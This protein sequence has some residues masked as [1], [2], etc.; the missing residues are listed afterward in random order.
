MRVL[1]F[2]VED[3]FHVL[4][5]E[6]TDA[7]S[8][9]PRLES[10]VARNTD[11]I[12]E[13]LAS[14]AVRATFFCVGWV[15]QHH[16]GVVHRIVAQGHE[17]GTHSFAHRPVHRQQR[18]E[19]EADLVRSIRLLE[20]LADR[21]VTCFRAPGFSLWPGPRW[22]FDALIANGISVDCSIFPRRCHDHSFDACLGAPFTIESS[23]GRLRE[24]PISA[25]RLLGTHV[26]CSGAGYFRLSPPALVRAHMRRDDYVMSYFHPRDFDVGQPVVEGLSL[27]RRFKARV[28]LRSALDRFRRVLD[29]FEFVCVGDAVRRI[30]WAAS[31]LVTLRTQ[32]AES[33]ADAIFAA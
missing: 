24:L 19:F 5:N 16:P 4:D 6:A 27:L 1:T 9:W 8:A 2:D 20:E 21:P 28:G 32:P 26:V 14:R 7:P 3:W 22:A 33:P 10:R 31:P 25:R 17:I 18:R 11:R 23:G 29:E 30:D 13:E 15:A 12:L